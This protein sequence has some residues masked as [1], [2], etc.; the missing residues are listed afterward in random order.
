MFGP[1]RHALVSVLVLLTLIP[2]TVLAQAEPEPVSPEAGLAALAVLA[3]VM[4]VVYVAFSIAFG[5]IVLVVSEVI[6]SGSYVRAIE[7]RSFDRPIRSVALGFGSIVIGFVGIFFLMFVV[8]ILV[9]LG[10][11]EPIVLLLM[12]AFFAGVLFLYVGSTI[13]TI[14]VG[15]YLLRKIRGGEA[16][17]WL[18]LV[19]GALVVNIP[20]VNFVLGFLVLFLGI[21]AMVDHWSSTNRGDSSGP[22]SQQPIEG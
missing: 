3:V 16:N 4:Y 9:E 19:V 6:R 7:Q 14:V 8:L 15:S 10:V 11:P 22:R 5:L 17:L 1:L 12:I 21:G 18:A 2:T 20:L 13:G